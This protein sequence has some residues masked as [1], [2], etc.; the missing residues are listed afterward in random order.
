MQDD[1]NLNSGYELNYRKNSIIY[2]CASELY[3]NAKKN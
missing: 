2:L 3:F 1:R